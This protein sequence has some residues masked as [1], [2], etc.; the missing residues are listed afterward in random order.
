M[1]EIEKLIERLD[2]WE[3][4]DAIIGDIEEIRQGDG[5]DNGDA[6]SAFADLCENYCA[7]KSHRCY[8]EAEKY[9]CKNFKWCGPKEE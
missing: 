2:D 8:V 7:N 3:G 1:T 6:D 5:V 9:R 4:C